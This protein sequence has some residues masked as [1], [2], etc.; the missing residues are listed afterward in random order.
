MH[1]ATDLVLISM[2]STLAGV[3]AA[4]GAFFTFARPTLRA[5]E[6]ACDEVET[7]SKALEVVRKMH[8][9]RATA[10]NLSTRSVWLSQGMLACI[11]RFKIRARLQ[12]FGSTAR[13]WTVD[14][15]V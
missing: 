6:R 2:L 10:L 3:T 13:H 15:I 5:M 11:K 14:L 12:I 8:D 4:L 1:A 9:S 7:A